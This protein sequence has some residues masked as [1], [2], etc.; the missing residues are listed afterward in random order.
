LFATYCVCLN[1]LQAS[2]LPDNSLDVVEVEVFVDSG[3]GIP[4]FS[5][6]DLLY[7]FIQTSYGSNELK[8]TTSD[9]STH[10]PINTPCRAPI[11]AQVRPLYIFKAS[12]EPE[13]SILCLVNSK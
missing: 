6:A 2:L 12:H 13:E 10:T 4:Y 3:Y 9:V 8:V 1:S 5:E 11:S 7:A